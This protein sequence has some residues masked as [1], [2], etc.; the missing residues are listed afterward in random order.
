MTTKTTAGGDQILARLTA[1]LSGIKV[2]L[3]DPTLSFNRKW[4]LQASEANIE[5]EIF[6]LAIAGLS[7]AERWLEDNGYLPD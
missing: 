1:R 2:R 5:D 3:T 7:S 4:Q 6:E